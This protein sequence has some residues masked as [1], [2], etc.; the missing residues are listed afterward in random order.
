MLQFVTGNGI[1]PVAARAILDGR[2]E[3]SRLIQNVKEVPVSQPYAQSFYHQKCLPADVKAALGSVMCL[4]YYRPMS[5][6][7]FLRKASPVRRRT[8][9]TTIGES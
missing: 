9:E 5:E 4:L 6:L 1:A 2:D 3:P 7:I 8:A